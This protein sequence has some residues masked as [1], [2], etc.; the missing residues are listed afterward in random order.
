MMLGSGGEGG[1]P[2]DG[3]ASMP[4][5]FPAARQYLQVWARPEHRVSQLGTCL[6]QVL[7][8]VGTSVVACCAG[9]SLRLSGCRACLH[10]PLHRAPKP[11]LAQ[12][13][14]MGRPEGASSRSHAPCREMV[15]QVQQPHAGRRVLPVPPGPI[16]SKRVMLRRRSIS[17]ISLSTYEAS[18]LDA[19]DCSGRLSSVLSGEKLR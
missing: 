16:R 4:R 14:T 10:F 12:A 18:Q 8:V 11:Q 13:P 9:H 5:G 1:H 17:S 7:A 3:L 2:P 15:E 6:Y 19:G